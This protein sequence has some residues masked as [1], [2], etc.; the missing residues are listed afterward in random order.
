MQIKKKVDL[1]N[2]SAYIDILQGRYRYCQLGK[3][4]T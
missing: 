1:V 4:Q 2:Y 3:S